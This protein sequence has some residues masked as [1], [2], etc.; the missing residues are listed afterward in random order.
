MTRILHRPV[1]LLLFLLACLTSSYAQFSG[2]ITG[3]VSD[4]SG[5]VV[6][7]AKLTLT[8]TDTGEVHTATSSSS[9]VYQFVSLA[10]GPYRLDA[11]AG[12]FSTA[13]SS[14]ILQTGQT[15]NL[16]VK[17]TVGTETQSI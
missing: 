3:E 1:Y 7:A 6:P 11:T 13:Q 9:G 14:F 5:S 15:L 16:P 10:P 2:V 12:G 17:L 4:P 8:K